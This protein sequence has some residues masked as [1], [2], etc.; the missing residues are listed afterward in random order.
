[1]KEIKTYMD[2]I[3]AVKSNDDKEIK[4]IKAY[5]IKKYLNSK[6]DGIIFAFDEKLKLIY[7][8]SE[9]PLSEIYCLMDSYFEHYYD[10]ETEYKPYDITCEIDDKKS[11]IIKSIDVHKEERIIPDKIKEILKNHPFLASFIGV[12]GLSSPILMTAGSLATKIKLLKPITFSGSYDLLLTEFMVY[13]GQA[14]TKK[15]YIPEALIKSKN[16]FLITNLNESYFNS[17]FGRNMYFGKIKED[18]LNPSINIPIILTSVNEFERTISIFPDDIEIIIPINDY[19]YSKYSDEI[20]E[21]IKQDAITKEE[22]D[23][24]SGTKIDELKQFSRVFRFLIKRKYSFDD[25][26]VFYL[27]RELFDLLKEN[28]KINYDDNFLEAMVIKKIFLELAV[29]NQLEE[30][31]IKDYYKEHYKIYGVEMKNILDN[32]KQEAIIDE[33]EDGLHVVFNMENYEKLKSG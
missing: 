30:E 11:I 18:V 9:A 13:N 32:L 16:Y 12:K 29:N 24:F 33:T 3:S 20:N 14:K 7:C 19:F 5:P 26:L 2:F 27:K 22:F 8:E 10:E 25:D 28:S 6:K 23:E 15:I 21:L 1:M 4:I 31:K 17:L